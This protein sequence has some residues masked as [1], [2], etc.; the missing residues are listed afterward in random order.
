MGYREVTGVS[1]RQAVALQLSDTLLCLG[2]NPTRSKT[3]TSRIVSIPGCKIEIRSPWAIT[4]AFDDRG[5]FKTR[6]VVEAQ[7]FLMCTIL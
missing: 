4:V 3:P 5:P 7:K 2:Y 6:S 1:P